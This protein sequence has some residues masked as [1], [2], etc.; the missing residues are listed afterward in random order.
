MALLQHER[1]IQL[2]WTE[3]AQMLV[4]SEARIHTLQPVTRELPVLIP[5]AYTPGG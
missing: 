2:S 5:Q 4:E 3:T 1:E